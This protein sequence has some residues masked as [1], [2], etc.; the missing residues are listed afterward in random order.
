MPDTLDLLVRRQSTAPKTLDEAAR[1]VR[2]VWSTGAAV[3][4]RDM[5]GPFLETLSLDPAHVDL[6][7]LRGASVLDDHAR[8]GV[9]SILGVV[10]DAGIAD[11][12]GWAVVKFS[13][14][15]EVE[16]VWQDVKD[17]IVRHVSVGYSVEAWQETNDPAT[18]TR[19]KR[20]VRWTPREISFVP[21]PAD[22]GASVRSNPMPDD[23]TL[24]T[25]ADP[26]PV[27]TRAAVNAEIRSI[28]RVAG[29]DAAF[30]DGLIDRNASAEEARAAAFDAMR[31]RSAA[32]ITTV[33]ASVGTDHD[34][35]EV[36]AG[37]MGEALYT[38]VNPSHQLSEP[39]RQYAGMTLPEMGR[40]ILRLRGISTTG[41]AAASVITRA[42]HTTSDFSIIL[43]DTVGRTLRQAY[44]AAPAG[45]KML[46][47]QTT[48]PDFRAKTRIQLS[49]AP[50]LEKVN[51]HGEFKS[52]TMADSKESY[53][54][55]TFGRIIGITRQALVNDDLGAFTDLSRRFG[56]A[57]AEFEAG[58]LVDLLTANAGA[59][60]AME[61]GAPLFHAS[62][63]NKASTAQQ[64]LSATLSD[65]RLAMRL[66][67]GLSGTL[68]NV[69]P[70]YLLVPAARETEAEKLL[71]TIA[72]TTTDDVNTFA[73]K[74]ELIVDPR[75]DG[76]SDLR[77]Y[78][79]ADP[80]Q[81]DGLE[82]AYL[83]GAP[84]PQIES[85]NGF[86][87]DGVRIKVRLDFG[88]GF[89][90]WRGWYCNDGAA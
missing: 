17:G 16:P 41:M 18:G 89:V 65:A 56:V 34:N 88:A 44:G 64:L 30:A 11:G 68:I 43:G 29:L 58:F 38:R 75:L 82:Y 39:A 6:A 80:A 74:L 28:A 21:L 63:G 32:P 5:A 19:S 13:R 45:V 22:A 70:K 83:E 36:R 35:P 62:H 26:A 48:A 73:G 4:R 15:P 33:R 27:T 1:T 52:G 53:K 37:W 60:P 55:D 12:E 51:E 85:Q 87:I 7:R 49:E 8:F 61:D 59:G 86:E 57:A 40:E 81:I 77:W 76:K 25:A 50:T 84:G 14:R 31:E 46:A 10:D 23:Q 66:Q 54:V 2:V 67:K 69:T 78:V 79:V 47:R 20:A 72:A 42:L 24:T 71:A 90:D 9:R 3:Q